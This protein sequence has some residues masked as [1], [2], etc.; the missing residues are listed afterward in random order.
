MENGR[1]TGPE[2]RLLLKMAR[3]AIKIEL[4]GLPFSLPR[5]TNP[6][7]LERRGAFV[8]IHK[9]G[10]L[11]GCIG[12]F[13]AD[14]P[15]YEIVG[16]MAISAAF[17][18]LRFRPLRSSEFGEI[19]LEIS[20]LTPLMPITDMNEIKIG[21]HGIYIIQEPFHGVLLPQVATKNGWDRLI[22]LDQ[23]CIKAGLASGCWK[24]PKTQVNIFSAE[25]FDERSEG[26]LS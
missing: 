1:L 24:N 23:T 18:D 7:L 26:L 14:R 16:D 15:L 6:N 2:R 9:H 21:L 3:Q 11:R 19:D 17:N 12:T 4:A 10:Q 13:S 5:V 8:T 22:F 25:I 20:A